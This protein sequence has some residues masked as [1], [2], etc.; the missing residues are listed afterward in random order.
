MDG[1]N[2]LRI[3]GWMPRVFL[4][5]FLIPRTV[6]VS[7]ILPAAYPG[8]AT[9]THVRVGGPFSFLIIIGDVA[10][11]ALGLCMPEVLRLAL[12]IRKSILMENKQ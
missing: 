1:S 6:F 4:A 5:L 10:S 11:M 8:G 2:K 3:T 12:G 7:A 9:A